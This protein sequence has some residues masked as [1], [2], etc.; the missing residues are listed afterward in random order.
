MRSPR[1]KVASASASLIEPLLQPPVETFFLWELSFLAL[2]EPKVTETGS[3]NLASKL[4]GI[5]SERSPS[6]F[7]SLISWSCLWKRTH[8]LLVAESEHMHHFEDIP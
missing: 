5:S 1:D 6:H 2:I 3:K 8:H 7:F 4:S